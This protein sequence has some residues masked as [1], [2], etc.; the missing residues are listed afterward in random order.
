[1]TLV[2]RN[3]ELNE[4]DI[5]ATPEMDAAMD[6]LIN[7]DEERAFGELHGDGRSRGTGCIGRGVESNPLRL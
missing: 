4:G 5:T 7:T 3:Q 1:M 2:I 6:E